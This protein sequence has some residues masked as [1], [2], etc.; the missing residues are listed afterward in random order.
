MEQWK[1]DKMCNLFKG[2]KCPFCDDEYEIFGISFKEAQ[3]INNECCK[4]SYTPTIEE[5]A[6]MHKKE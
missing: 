3:E 6:E 4:N 2:G 5:I 1:I